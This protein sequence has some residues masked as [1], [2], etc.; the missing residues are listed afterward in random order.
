M[1][2][3]AVKASGTARFE[4]QGYEAH[5]NYAYKGYISRDTVSQARNLLTLNVSGPVTANN[6]TT[7][8]GAKLIDMINAISS[9]ATKTVEIEGHWVV[10]SSLSWLSGEVYTTIADFSIFIDWVH[11]TADWV[12]T[13]SGNVRS[14]HVELDD[15]GNNVSM[16]ATNNSTEMYLSFSTG[17]AKEILSIPLPFSINVAFSTSNWGSWSIITDD[18][19]NVSAT[20]TPPA[21]TP[22]VEVSGIKISELSAV[23]A[24]QDDDLFVLSQDNASDGTYDASYNVTLT[25]LKT[26]LKTGL[27]TSF[28]S[29]KWVAG[30]TLSISTTNVTSCGI[31]IATGLTNST[32]S[33]H[34]MGKFD[35]SSKSLKLTQVY[36]GG[37]GSAPAVPEDHTLTLDS[38]LQDM[39]IQPGSNGVIVKAKFDANT[40]YIELTGTDMRG[41]YLIALS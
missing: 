16:L 40:L 6:G 4:G 19:I 30:D 17:P 18:G 38:T 37:A 26:N 22:T 9:S 12:Y 1:G 25:N 23:S 7:H 35:V 28:Q 13:W 27:S 21:E 36:N 5:S 32:D 14:G 31:S 8:D 29:G 15:L 3:R 2:R 34:I 24:L 41:T 39:N 20:P 10:Y 33:G 11:M